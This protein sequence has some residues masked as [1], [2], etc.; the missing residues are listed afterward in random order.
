MPRPTGAR[1]VISSS[2][3][4]LSGCSW[5][6]LGNQTCAG[7][8][9]QPRTADDDE[10]TALERSTSQSG[11]AGQ[12]FIECDASFDAGQRVAQAVMGPDAERQVLAHWAG[13]IEILRIGAESLVVAVGRADQCQDRAALGTVWP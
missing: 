13:D 2:H 10:K 4:S 9:S 6:D 12:Y 7:M 11:E 3:L 5:G 8:L 1:S